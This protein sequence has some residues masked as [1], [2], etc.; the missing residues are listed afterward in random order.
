SPDA[1]S[2]ETLLSATQVPFVTS[3][4]YVAARFETL[5]EI[6][7][8]VKD[9]PYSTSHIASWVA[10][11]TLLPV[12]MRASPCDISAPISPI[13]VVVKVGLGEPEP[14]VVNG[15]IVYVPDDCR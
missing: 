14:A 8:E 12:L 15:E 11:D 5:D 10:A 13:C 7:L 4:T 9:A 2:S 1:E 3:V 6:P